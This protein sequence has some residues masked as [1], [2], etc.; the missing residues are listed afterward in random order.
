MIIQLI[1]QN[2]VVGILFA[3]FAAIGGI[4]L[5]ILVPNTTILAYLLLGVAGLAAIVVIIVRAEWGLYALVFMTYLHLSDVLIENHHAPS[6][7]KIFV[8]LLLGLIFIRWI[9]FRERP[10]NGWVQT[11]LLLACYGLLILSSFLF[12]SDPN[13]VQVG[14]IDYIKNGLVTILVTMLLVRAVTLRGVIWSL[15]AAGIILASIT[16]YQGLTGTFDNNYW[17]FAQPGEVTF[18]NGYRIAG[19]VNT[20]FYALILVV[21]VPLAIGRLRQEKSLV[22]Q[23][24]AGWAL[25]ACV[26]SIVL[27]Y[28]RGGFLAL[29]VVTGLM[30]IRRMPKL[31]EVIILLALGLGIWQFLPVSYIDRLQTITYLS[32]SKDVS[33]SDHSINGRTSEMMAAAYMF[34]DHL[35]TGV[36]YSNYEVHYLD[37]SEEIG[38][39]PRRE[40]RQPHNLFLEIAAETGIIGLIVFGAILWILFKGLISAKHIFVDMG[41]QEY[42]QMVGDFMVSMI[43]YFTGSMFLHSIY[44]RYFWL[45]VGIA[46]AIPFVAKNEFSNLGRGKVP[47]TELFSSH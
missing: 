40:Q 41:M 33:F 14:F 22:L 11:G 21:L 12:A 31:H 10:S 32:P 44:P 18:G 24:I 42:S 30:L 2:K 47:G 38:L 17:G 7:A 26:I 5:A 35:I 13:R 34:A 20:N 15:L 19:P 16:T 9:I 28:S 4:F 8:P 46:L 36:G 45:L 27:T 43:G 37:Y 25:L 6:I 3:A 29:A 23:I 1:I 39:D